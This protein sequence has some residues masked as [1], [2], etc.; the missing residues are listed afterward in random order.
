MCVVYLV[1]KIWFGI[2]LERGRFLFF[3]VTITAVFFTEVIVVV[4]VSRY[5]S[6]LW[7]VGF[8]HTYLPDFFS[9]FFRLAWAMPA[10]R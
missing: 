6:A 9:A 4:A 8:F 5:E 7:C 3:I 2:V 1:S 10:M